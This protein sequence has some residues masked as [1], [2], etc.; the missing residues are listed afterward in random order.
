MKTKQAL[1]LSTL[2]GLCS[3]L[4]FAA[5]NEP[6]KPELPDPETAVTPQMIKAKNDVNAYLSDATAF[7]ECTNSTRKHNDM[8]NEMNDVADQF[9]A[10]I[11]AY[12]A[13]MAG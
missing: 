3:S 6:T 8:V 5:C 1:V 12:K 13:R 2:L 10:I 11:R 9:N 4:A 7:L